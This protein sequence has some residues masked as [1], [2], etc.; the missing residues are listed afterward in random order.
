MEM[1]RKHISQSSFGNILPWRTGTPL[2][3]RGPLPDKPPSTATLVHLAWQLLEGTGIFAEGSS[4]KCCCSLLPAFCPFTLLL[5][6]LHLLSASALLCSIHVHISQPPPTLLPF[7]TSPFVL[8]HWQSRS[9]AGSQQGGKMKG[10]MTFSEAAFEKKRHSLRRERKRVLGSLEEN[11]GGRALMKQHSAT[12]QAPRASN[13]KR[14]CSSRGR[15]ARNMKYSWVPGVGSERPFLFPT[16]PYEETRAKEETKWHRLG[17]SKGESWWNGAQIMLPYC[18]PMPLG[19]GWGRVLNET[20]GRTS[21]RSKATSTRDMFTA[22]IEQ[23]TWRGRHIIG[24]RSSGGDQ[25]T[26]KVRATRGRHRAEQSQKPKQSHWMLSWLQ[27]KQILCLTPTAPR[28]P[29][30]QT[31]KMLQWPQ[32]PP[33]TCHQPRLPWPSQVCRLIWHV[34]GKVRWAARAGLGRRAAPGSQ[35]QQCSAGVPSGLPLPHPAPAQHHSATSLSLH[36]PLSKS[37]G[38]QLS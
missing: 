24:V 15:K 9:H 6:C 27:A 29:L 34:W 13:M 20:H 28:G 14:F 19:K 26:V 32:F 25:R 21:C 16:H 31:V 23:C 8:Y 17:A 37:Q 1:G 30:W 35:T 33:D 5:P 3:F 22:P 7:P 18:S 2:F 10:T 36:L 38:Q 11:Q 12:K 4:A